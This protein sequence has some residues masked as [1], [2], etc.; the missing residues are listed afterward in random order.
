MF[1]FSHFFSRFIIDFDHFLVNFGAGSRWP[2]F[3]NMT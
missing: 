3:E 2:P 1:T